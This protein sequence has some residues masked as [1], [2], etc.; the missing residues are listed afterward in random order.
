MD[1]ILSQT[2]RRLIAEM[3]ARNFPH[4]AK[5]GVPAETAGVDD[6][7]QMAPELYVGRVGPGGI[8]A[9]SSGSD[10]GTDETGE[11]DDVPGWADVPAWTIRTDGTGANPVMKPL[12]TSKRVYNVSSSDIPADT[13]IVMARTKGGRWVVVAAGLGGSGDWDWYRITGSAYEDSQPGAYRLYSWEGVDLVD[14]FSGTLAG[15]RADGRSGTLNAYR[16]PSADYDDTYDAQVLPPIPSGQVVLGRPSLTYSGF[17]ELTPWGGQKRKVLRRILDVCVAC[18]DSTGSPSE[19]TLAVYIVYQKNR[20][21][22]RD[23]VITKAPL[24]DSEDVGG[25]IDGG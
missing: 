9:M 24:T 2:D 14:N 7:E 20:Y 22:A 4:L 1:Y 12:P 8:D 10:T 3:V 16:A 19:P 5:R 17:H 25:A 18:E 15:W 13:W 23:L 6:Q 11:S 21:Y